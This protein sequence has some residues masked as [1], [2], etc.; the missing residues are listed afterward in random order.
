MRARAVQHFYAFD[1]L[2]LNGH[3]LGGFDIIIGT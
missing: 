1:L 3:E 2:W